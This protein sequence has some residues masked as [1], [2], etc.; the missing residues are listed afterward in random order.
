MEGEGAGWYVWPVEGPAAACAGCVSGTFL[1][2][3][4]GVGSF[5]GRPSV[6]LFCRG[7]ARPRGAAAAFTLPVGVS[8]GVG[9]ELSRLASV[10]RAP[11]SYTSAYRSASSSSLPAGS[12]S[13]SASDRGDP[14]RSP[15]P[16]QL[17]FSRSDLPA[18]IQLCIHAILSTAL[19]ESAPQSR[20]NWRPSFVAGSTR[21]MRAEP[22][23]WQT[24]APF[25][26][27][28]KKSSSSR[29][30]KADWRLTL[31]WRI[32]CGLLFR[33]PFASTNTARWLPAASTKRLG[34]PELGCDICDDEGC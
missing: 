11:R 1:A 28:E 22:G 2:V 31:S 24:T 33:T 32:S 8:R 27:H 13:S 16:A 19:P 25:C 4:G 20:T 10:R 30:N 5:G 23:L 18:A 6:P 15:Q 29:N 3:G 7:V 17:S 26:Y 12:S 9:K 34:L 14:S 21:I